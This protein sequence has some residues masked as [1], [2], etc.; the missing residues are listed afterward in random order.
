MV[1]WSS[2]QLEALSLI[3]LWLPGAN[4]LFPSCYQCPFFQLFL[5]KQFLPFLNLI[6]ISEQIVPP[7][8]R[9]QCP[10]IRTRTKVQRTR[11]KYNVRVQK[12]KMNS[13][14]PATRN[15][16][17]C[18]VLRCVGFCCLWSLSSSFLVDSS[19]RLTVF[20]KNPEEEATNLAFYAQSTS[21]VKS[22]RN[23]LC[24]HTINAKKIY[25]LKLVHRPIFLI[26]F[27]KVTN[28]NRPKNVLSNS[29]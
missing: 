13:D 5:E 20:V 3:R 26:N 1:Q 7:L 15:Q 6:D 2:G 8:L 10:E 23:T 18:T 14:F 24:Q 25:T 12:Y 28:K 4:S 29:K 27:F 21:T 9:S 19:L 22:G 11:T 17:Y 16:T